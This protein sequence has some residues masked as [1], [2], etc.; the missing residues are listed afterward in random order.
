VAPGT[1]PDRLSPEASAARASYV[2]RAL[3]DL[4]A[5]VQ[6]GYTDMPHLEYDPDLA[7][8]RS[9]KEYVQLIRRL[10]AAAPRAK[11]GS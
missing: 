3:Q 11:A 7:A 6:H 5:A 2:A 8:V 4:A 1:A 9:E 10:K